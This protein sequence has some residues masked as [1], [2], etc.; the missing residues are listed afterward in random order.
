MDAEFLM[1]DFKEEGGGHG[2]L[3]QGDERGLHRGG[4]GALSGAGEGSRHH[5]HHRADPGQTGAEA[6]HGRDGRVDGRRQRHRRPRRRA[7]R[8][9][10]V[11]RTRS[12][13]PEARCHP[14]RLHGPAKPSCH[15]VEP[16]LR[17]QPAPP[18][19]RPVPGEGRQDR[20]EHGGRGHPWCHGDQGRRNHLAAAG[21]QAVGRAA[22]TGQAAAA[23]PAP[24]PE[25]KKASV[26][27][28]SAAVHH[29]AARRC[30]DWGWLRR[31]RS[32]RISRYSCSPVSSAT[33]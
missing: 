23:A 28:M 15:P 21:A 24:K 14:H 7:G 1:L 19:D 25:P 3:R 5:H 10:R 27:A 12:R 22:E 30:S 11:D 8:Q 16:A 6:D 13:G 4:D 31:R 26:W 2:R 29:W 18:A 17:H 33:W 32:W 20:R 9:L